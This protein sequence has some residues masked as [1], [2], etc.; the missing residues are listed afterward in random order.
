[1]TLDLRPAA[2]AAA[3][4]SWALCVAMQPG[5]TEEGPWGDL[6]D[7]QRAEMVDGML[8]LI[9]AAAPL[10]AAAAVDDAC[11]RVERYAETRGRGADWADDQALAELAGMEKAVAIIRGEV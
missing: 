9:E 8:P 5:E 6:N 2:E 3:R 10:I 4:A 1:M 7:A 11:D